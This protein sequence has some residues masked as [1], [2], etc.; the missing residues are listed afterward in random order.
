MTFL[1]ITFFGN[2]LKQWSIAL[3]IFAGVYVTLRVLQA[4]LKKHFHTRA[5]SEDGNVSSFIK[6]LID[7]IHPLVI[8]MLALYGSAV[9]L[10]LSS[11]FFTLATSI[12]KIS[13]L[14]QL[15]LWGNT[16]ISFWMRSYQKAYLEKEAA[17]VTT[18]RAVSFVLRVALISI[19]LLLILDNIPGVEVTT[20]IASLGIGGIAVALAVQNI[21]ADLFA[22]LS[23]AFDKPFVIGDFIIIDNYM[24]TIEHIGLKTTRIR[25]LSGEQIIMSNNDLLSSRI[26]NYKR[27]YERRVVFTIGV[28]YQTSVQQLKEIPVL[29][30][31]I[32]EVQKLTR[33]D[34][35]HFKEYGKFSLNFE[36]VYYV[37]SSDY[38]VYMNTQEAINLQI[39]SIFLQKHIEFAYPTQVVQLMQQT[40]QADVTVEQTS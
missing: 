31:E 25:S 30:K 12:I 32:I 27:M 5:V 7:R 26:R 17:R 11:T 20:L 29:I 23:I 28:V 35:A 34:R 38:N 21:L 39:Y 1:K 36:V 18:M 15:S 6:Q 33:F 13:L 22:S 24:G 37:L 9:S 4:L 3:G 16:A 10:N 14:L 19:V 2:D 8:V 40:N